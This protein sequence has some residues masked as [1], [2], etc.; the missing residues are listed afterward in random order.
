MESRKKHPVESVVLMIFAGLG[1]LAAGCAADTTTTVNATDS[2]YSCR[3]HIREKFENVEKIEIHSVSGECQVS[4]SDSPAVAVHV[5]Y[6][7]RPA[8][9]MEPRMSLDESSRTLVLNEQWRKGGGTGRVLW[10]LTVPASTAV[11]FSSSS[12]GLQVK[13]LKA[14]VGVDTSSGKVVVE[15]IKSDVTIRTASGSVTVAD[16]SGDVNVHSASGNITYRGCTGD[17]EVI[18]ASGVINKG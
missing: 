9:A 7:V 11:D 13:G 5:E 17:L 3:G 18:T 6:N 14:A 2:R 16:V 15:N 8:G 1:A 10:T 12:G 4:V